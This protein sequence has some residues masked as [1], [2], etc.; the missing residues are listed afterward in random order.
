MAHTGLCSPRYDAEEDEKM[1]EIATR[2][3]NEWDTDGDKACAKITALS[4]FKP[5]F[6]SISTYLLHICIY[7]RDGRRYSISMPLICL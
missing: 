4:L 6:A 5:S 7:D 3:L 2:V 1:K